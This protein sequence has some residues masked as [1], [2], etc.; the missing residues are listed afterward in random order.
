MLTESTAMETNTELEHVLFLT[1]RR[2]SNYTKQ[3]IQVNGDI[4][5]F[6]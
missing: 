4:F 3:Y 1:I 6:S 2:K 5:K